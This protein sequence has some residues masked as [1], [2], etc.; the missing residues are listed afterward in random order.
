MD[1]T[2]Q[3]FGNYLVLRRDPNS[4][5]HSALYWICQCKCSR[6]VSLRSDV[7]RKGLSSRCPMCIAEERIE[8]R[9]TKNKP[10]EL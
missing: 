3:Q 2:G 7:L 5:S 10:S 6:E 1:L 4:I 8:K 9:K